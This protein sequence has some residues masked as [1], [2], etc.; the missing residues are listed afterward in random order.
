M[1]WTE[2]LN[3][4]PGRIALGQGTAELLNWA[5]A[6]N[7]ADNRPHRHTFFEVCQ[8]GGYGRGRFTVEGR[9][10]ELAPGTVF[11]A[12]PGVVHQIVNTDSPGMELFW[13]CFGWTS[14]DGQGVGEVDGLLR[15]FAYSD[16]VTATDESGRLQAQWR[17]LSVLAEDGVR[18]GY[19]AQI[20][21]Q[22]TVLLLTIA[23]IGAGTDAGPILETTEPEI[24]DR[25]A[26]LAV[27]FIH[28]N[29]YRP[30]GVA[31]IANQVHASPR[32]L[33]RLF[34]RFT[35]TSPAAYITQAR[36]DRACGLLANSN[37][38][39][40]EVAEAVGYPDVHYF[41]R[42]F[43]QRLGCPPG[44]YRRRPDARPVPNVQNPG[45]LV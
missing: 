32:H 28:D 37:A 44:E 17:A 5:Y 27:R 33:S 25:A 14:G 45:A 16:A 42:V 31:E 34:A 36:L 41:T 23:Q 43:A 10:H 12:R 30:L 20:A 1:D 13:V 21:A 39:I 2:R 9:E 29:L 35:G 26:R 6:P 15:A 24:G 7:L 19:A 8:V 22:I 18:P 40:K 38:P 3:R 4:G 11:I